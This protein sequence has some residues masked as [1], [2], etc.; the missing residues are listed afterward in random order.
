MEG[1]GSFSAQAYYD[2]RYRQVPPTLTDA[3]DIADIQLQHSL[4]T[5]GAHSIVWGGEYRYNWDH[6]TN[7][8]F[9]AFLPASDRQT[10]ASLFA[11]DE[12]ALRDNVRLIAGARYERNPYTGAEFLPTLRLSWR[13]SPA[14]SLWS[15]WSRT[16]RAPS[17]LDVDAYIPGT[18]PFLLAGGPRVRA[19]VARVFELGYR[20]QVGQD[21]SY[22]VTLYRNLY[23]HLRTQDLTSQGTIEFGNQM[24]GRRTASK[25]GPATR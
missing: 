3:V 23:D 12:I 8:R 24:N 25:P 1:G 16:V 19:E 4:P 9:V 18:A 21:L 13:V 5:L 15:A 10:W 14:H 22:S 20:G 2:Y 6:V 7:S 11:Q 17:R